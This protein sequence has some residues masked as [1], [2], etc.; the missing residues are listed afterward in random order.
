MSVS[1]FGDRGSDSSSDSSM[2]Q[3]VIVAGSSQ[4]CCESKGC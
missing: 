4:V 2:L 1:L 3:M